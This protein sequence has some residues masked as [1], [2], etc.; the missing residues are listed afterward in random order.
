MFVKMI[1]QEIYIERAR[2]AMT[3]NE[4]EVEAEKLQ[5]PAKTRDGMSV[6]ILRYLDDAGDCKVRCRANKLRFHYGFAQSDWF[7]QSCLRHGGFYACK[8]L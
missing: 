2:K 5:R 8:A 3:A 7:D 6:Y 1:L 4:I